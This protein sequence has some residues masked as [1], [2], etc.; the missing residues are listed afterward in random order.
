M[1]K[2]NEDRRGFLKTG[3]AV[4]AGMTGWMLFGK[5]AEA[6][7]KAE[8]NR[9]VREWNETP[10]ADVLL[11]FIELDLSYDNPMLQFDVPAEKPRDIHPNFTQE[12]PLPAR[13]LTVGRHTAREILDHQHPQEKA[14]GDDIWAIIRKRAGLLHWQHSHKSKH[15]GYVTTIICN[16]PSGI[17]VGM[18]VAPVQLT[19]EAMF[20]TIP[21]TLLPRK[22]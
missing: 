22:A 3:G 4:A 18:T 5:G 14:N 12:T 10:Q 20:L 6:E 19:S 9:V 21:A 2:V 15:P 11:H 16:C 7:E 13:R 8:G 17:E 1:K